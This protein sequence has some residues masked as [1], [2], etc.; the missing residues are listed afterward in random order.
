MI[1]ALKL[2]RRWFLYLTRDP[3]DRWDADAV[4]HWPLAVRRELE[5]NGK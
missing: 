3:G 4:S 2:A 5:R 1:R